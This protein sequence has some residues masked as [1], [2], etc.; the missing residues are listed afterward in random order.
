MID[1]DDDE[2]RLLYVVVVEK[3]Q[4]HFIYAS[5]SEVAGKLCKLAARF[6]HSSREVRA[7]NDRCME[8]RV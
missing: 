3:A 7:A 4:E 1:L 2:V 6:A 5:T 8:V